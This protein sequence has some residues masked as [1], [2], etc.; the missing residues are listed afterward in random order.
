MDT[1]PE[2]S[3]VVMELGL[4]IE[5]VIGDINRVQQTSTNINSKS[6]D[7]SS[8]WDR[9]TESTCKVTHL[10]EESGTRKEQV[11]A[12]DRDIAA[13]EDEIKVLQKKI[14]ETKSK[15]EHLLNFEKEAIL[16]EV[17]IGL[18]HV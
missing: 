10:K 16:N 5:Q 1:S 11:A 6:K 3:E 18:Q 4:M 7:Q 2:I 12:C 15:K 14:L 9:A 13:W 8:E 17:E